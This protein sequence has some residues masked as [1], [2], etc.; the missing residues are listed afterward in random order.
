MQVKR[1]VFTTLLSSMF[2]S[3]L[4]AT[5]AERE[6]IIAGIPEQPL[7][8]QDKNG[9]PGGL[10]YKIVDTVFARLGVKT[11]VVFENSST[12]LDKSWQDGSFDVIYCYSKNKEREQFLWY[13]NE[14]HITI[15]WK[16]WTSPE[17]FAKRQINTLDDMKG[18][19]VGATVGY[20]YSKDFWA[21]GKAGVYTLDEV[22]K[23]EAQAP[24]LLAKRIDVMVDHPFRVL[25]EAKENNY[26]DKIKE[27]PGVVKEAPYYT[28]FVKKSNYPGL[29][30]LVKKYDETLKK[31]K[32]DGTI[33]KIYAEYNMEY[34]NK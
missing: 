23:N 29:E 28:T 2:V 26:M 16:Y 31:M 15:R 13:P 3:S 17:L 1:I 7:R 5:A 6:L 34:S 25:F 32:E 10:D 4:H 9:K 8:Y 14:S 27:H 21:K 18:L 20:S 30:G 12:R 22:V 24:K 11:K 19:K 33:A